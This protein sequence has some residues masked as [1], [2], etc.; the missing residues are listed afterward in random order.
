[1]AVIYTVSRKKEPPYTFCTDK[2][3]HAVCCTELSVHTSRG[4]WVIVTKWC[5]THKCQLPTWLTCCI[6]TPHVTSASHPATYSRFNRTTLWLTVPATPRDSCIAFSWDIRLHQSIL[7]ATKQPDINLVDYASGAFCKSVYRCR[8]HDISHLKERLIEQW[9][10]FDHSI[11]DRAVNQWRERLC[12][13]ISEKGTHSQ[14][15]I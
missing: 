2:Y 3:K 7:L 11:T 14:R 10:H 13:C 1:M 8:I 5:H 4:I 6:S 9:R 15:Q 12:R